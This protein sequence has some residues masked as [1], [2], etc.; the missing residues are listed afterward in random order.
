MK[1]LAE[2][3]GA[4]IISIVIF[5][6]PIVTTLSWAC[7]WDDFIKYILTIICTSEL[8]LLFVYILPKVM[9]DEE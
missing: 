5:A 4:I 6:I 9:L 8:V 1:T 2:I 3:I 7:S